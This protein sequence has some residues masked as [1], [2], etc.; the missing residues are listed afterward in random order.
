MAEL[1]KGNNLFSL[2]G[3]ENPGG[4]HDSAVGEQEVETIRQKEFP[5]HSSPISTRVP[6]A[7]V[8]QE[9]P[10]AAL[11]RV[12]PLPKRLPFPHSCLQH[13]GGV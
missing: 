13:L 11:L 10:G 8:T 2:G 9:G 3:S 1:K 7:Q 5:V 6:K 4:T 12:A